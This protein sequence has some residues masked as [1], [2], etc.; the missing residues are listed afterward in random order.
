MELLRESFRPEE[1]LPQVA[2]RCVWGRLDGRWLV[3]RLGKLGKSYPCLERGRMSK[4]SSGP[5]ERRLLALGKQVSQIAGN[6]AEGSLLGPPLPPR[7]VVTSA[8]HARKVRYRYFPESLFG[9]PAWEMLLELLHAEMEGRQVTVTELCEAASTQ[10]TTTLRWLSVLVSQGL[11][12][13]RPDPTDRTSELIA[14]SSTT[15][16]AFRRYFDDLA[17]GR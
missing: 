7:E 6:L 1:S 10:G 14:L 2:D 16:A 5:K 9:E 4:H 13:R 15:S 17:K 3:F 11:V 12:L 8:I